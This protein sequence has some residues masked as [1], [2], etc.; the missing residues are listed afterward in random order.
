MRAAWLQAVRKEGLLSAYR[1]LPVAAASMALYKALYFG[2]YVSRRGTRFVL[3]DGSCLFCARPR[4]AL[5]GGQRGG[6]RGSSARVCARCRAWSREGR[7]AP[8]CRPPPQDSAKPLVLGA[9][10]PPATTPLGLALRTGLA[11]ATTFTAASV[12]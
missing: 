4:G 5:K 11:A 8:P 6:A 7:P 9:D 1:G 12:S 3:G 2:L 10:A